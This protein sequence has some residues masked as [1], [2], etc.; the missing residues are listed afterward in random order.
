MCAARKKKK[1]VKLPPEYS[2]P[3]TPRL[4]KLRILAMD[5]GSKNF[6]IACVGVE[7]GRPVILANA[8]LRFPVNDLVN[9]PERREL[10]LSELKPWFDTFKPQ[11]MIAERFQTRGNGGPLIE[12]VAVMLGL[13]AG[14]YPKIKTKFITAS[15]W[16]NA[17]KRRFFD[18]RLL[19]PDLLVQPHP[20][21]AAMIGVYGLEFGL[22]RQL[23][24]DPFKIVKSVE[25]SSLVPLK[26]KRETKRKPAAPV[27]R[28]TKSKKAN[29]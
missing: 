10:F 20:F 27:S 21:D 16:K 9:F 19:Y 3:K 23:K 12:Y 22:K 1:V 28:R 24:Y 6:G 2:L 17:F 5:P 29:R 14:T 15:T 25:A 7:N 8:Q 4:P 26:V 11:A 18:L 13:L